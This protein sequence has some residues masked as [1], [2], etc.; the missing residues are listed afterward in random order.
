MTEKMLKEN[1]IAYGL[2]PTGTT[3]SNESMICE[4]RIIMVRRNTMEQT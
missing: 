2:K 3:F 4:F 1:D